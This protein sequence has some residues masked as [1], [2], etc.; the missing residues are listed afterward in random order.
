MTTTLRR[1]ATNA[2]LAG[3]VAL[4]CTGGAATTT[5]LVSAA[6][7]VTVAH[8]DEWKKSNDSWWYQTGKSYATGWKKIGGAWYYF[9]NNGWMKTGWQKI[10]GKWYYLKSSGTMATGWNKV[11]GS[12]YYHTSSGAMKTGWNK[13]SGTW[14]YHNGSGAM[15]TGWN[16]IGGKW[17]YFNRSGAMQAGRW[18]GNYY[19]KNDGSMATNQ[20]IGDYHVNANGVWDQ[21]KEVYRNI[22]ID[23]EYY[24]ADGKPVTFTG[25]HVGEF[26][27]TDKGYGC[28]GAANASLTMNF[29]SYNKAADF[30][31]VDI[32]GLMHFH[33]VYS[34]L[35][36]SSEAD[37]MITI[38]SIVVEQTTLLNGGRIWSGTVYS[39]D[40]SAYHELSISCFDFNPGNG[41]VGIKVTKENFGL[42]GIFSS[43]NTD[44]YIVKLI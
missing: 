31:T 18:I 33:G 20:W 40:K 10:S 23:D 38:P 22:V 17:Y 25:K 13:V 8:A 35:H 29:K 15:L 34:N 5:A 37:E 12:W 42:G 7:D 27:S 2:A 39:N 24:G 19:V 1:K 14:Y 26:A 6:S 21:T 44:R 3:I 30:Y 41:T 36:E 32:T 16:K 9:D 43:Y 11:S 4:G 28:L